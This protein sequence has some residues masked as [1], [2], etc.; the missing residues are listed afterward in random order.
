M[1]TLSQKALAISPSPTL[2]IDARAKELKS[3]GEDVIGFGAGEPDFDTPLHIRE[4]AKKA[5]D[6]GFTRYTPA[7]GIPELKKAICEK[8]NKDNGLDYQPGQIVVSNGAKHSLH[9]AFSAILTPGDEVIIP[10]PYWVSY[11]ELVKLNDGIPVILETKRENNY[12][13]DTRA[14]KCNYFVQKPLF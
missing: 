3:A 11:P 2:M 7:S 4:A 9:N 14:G 10:A 1:L 13:T 5:I 12:S 8:L 6:E